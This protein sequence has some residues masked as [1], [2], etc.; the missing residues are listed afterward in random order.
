MTPDQITAACAVLT[1][2][3]GVAWAVYWFGGL[4]FSLKAFLDEWKKFR[5]DPD[6]VVMKCAQHTQAIADL[7]ERVDDHGSRIAAL[8]DMTD[9]LPE[10]E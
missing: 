1:L 5:L 9:V 10:A 7:R 3:G 8:E 2:I 4:H 6:A